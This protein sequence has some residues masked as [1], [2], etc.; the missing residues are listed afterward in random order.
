MK[1]LKTFLIMK[2]LMTYEELIVTNM[3]DKIEEANKSNF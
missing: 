1:Y 3:K 2:Y